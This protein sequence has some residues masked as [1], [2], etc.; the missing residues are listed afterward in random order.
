MLRIMNLPVKIEWNKLDVNG[1]FFIPCLD[2][3]PVEEF[4]KREGARRRFNV[5]CK[6]VVE[7]GRYGLR[8]WRIE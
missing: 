1:S 3:K 6:Q 5:V 2:A 4:I 7:K 8:C